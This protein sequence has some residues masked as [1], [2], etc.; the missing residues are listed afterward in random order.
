VV[1]LAAMDFTSF[2]S[3]KTGT[4]VWL[5]G[6]IA[7]AVEGIPT[8]SSMRIPRLPHALQWCLNLGVVLLLFL[9]AGVL[10]L[11][12]DADMRFCGIRS[13]AISADRAPA[14]QRAILVT[15]VRRSVTRAARE[16]LPAM[17]FNPKMKHYYS[18]VYACMAMGL[19]DTDAAEIFARAAVRLHP[20]DRISLEHLATIALTRGRKEEGVA[21]MEQIVDT[22][23]C[24]PNN[25][26]VTGLVGIYAMRGQTQKSQELAQRIRDVTVLT[27]S[28]PAPANRAGRVPLDVTFRWSEQNSVECYDLYFWKTGEQTPKAPVARK[29]KQSQWIPRKP[30]H[31]D[32]VY[33]WRVRAYGE[34]G[35]KQS[36]LWFFRTDKGH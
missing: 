6:I 21:L 29:L 32:T 22:F 15:P 36:E 28:D 23:G 9:F 27:P 11:S 8:A 17:Q 19:G 7:I 20:N 25:P 18:H 33:F 2:L 13:F 35:E 12:I 4:L 30:L 26:L 1:G 3:E 34:Y 24:D 10:A 31:P 14:V 5:A 16:V